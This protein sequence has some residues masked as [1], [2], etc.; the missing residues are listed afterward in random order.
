MRPKLDPPEAPRPAAP[1]GARGGW[2]LPLVF[3]GAIAAGVA[4]VLRAPAWLFAAAFGALIAAGLA[5]VVISAWFPAAADRRCPAC[6]A[7][8][9]ERLDLRTTTGLACGRCGWRDE[10]ASSF[11]LAEEEGALEPLVLAERAERARG[12]SAASART[13]PAR[14]RIARDP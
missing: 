4:V 8:S 12:G 9:I 13:P 7:L 1:A 6:G 5:W 11:L 10:S 14:A 3:L 2:L